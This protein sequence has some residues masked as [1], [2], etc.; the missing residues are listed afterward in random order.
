MVDYVPKKADLLALAAPGGAVAAPLLDHLLLAL[1]NHHAPRRAPPLECRV[2]ASAAGLPDAVAFVDGVCRRFVLFRAR[3]FKRCSMDRGV[4]GAAASDV[5]GAVRQ[6]RAAW[7]APDAAAIFLPDARADGRWRLW[8]AVPRRAEVWC[9]DTAADGDRCCDPPV[10][11]RIIWNE[12]SRERT[13]TRAPAVAVRSLGAPSLP[14]ARAGDSAIVAFRALSRLLRRRAAFEWDDA[15]AGAASVL[16]AATDDHP[17]VADGGDAAAA[18]YTLQR[19][20]LVLLCLI[21]DADAFESAV[22]APP[23]HTLFT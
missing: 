1:W 12:L 2:A 17:A 23:V 15:D 5:D 7:L 4:A 18:V 22:A 11:V 10:R 21:D 6:L 9:A 20:Y 8:V 16:R 19:Q 13:G 14:A 3:V